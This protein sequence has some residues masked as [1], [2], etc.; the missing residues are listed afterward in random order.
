MNS[1][2]EL[3]RIAGVP[4]YL[5]FMSLVV[6]FFFFRHYF[7]GG[8]AD[9]MSM[10]L[11]IVVGFLASIL[12]HELGHVFMADRFGVETREIVF[13]TMGG[14]AV[15]KR[16]LPAA[17]LKRVLVYAIGPAVNFAL[18]Y[19]FQWG[20]Q[21]ARDSHIPKLAFV[22]YQLSSINFMLAWFN[23]LPAYPL[24]GGHTLE[25]VL[26]PIIGPKWGQRAV[27]ALGLLVALGFVYLGAM[28]LPDGIFML[29][30]AFAMV[31]LN[32]GVLRSQGLGR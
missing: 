22:L 29:V 14:V 6:M 12:L 7:V 15:F 31:E 3:G 32:A 16:S 19:L 11:L 21:A 26:Y 4:V 23:M 9:R 27:G 30:L 20:A 1:R 5:E 13:T 2:V 10:G 28:S 25:A 24:D 17:F 18:Y 8:D